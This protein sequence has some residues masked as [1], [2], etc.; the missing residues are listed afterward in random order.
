MFSGGDLE[1]L[2]NSIMREEKI[3]NRYKPII[4]L[5]Q[6]HYSRY[7]LYATREKKERVPLFSMRVPYQILSILE[8]KY[9]EK[10][11]AILLLK[12]FSAKTGITFDKAVENLYQ[13]VV[14]PLLKQEV[15]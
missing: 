5:E 12:E 11:E 7:Y 15:E 10:K 6:R 2:Y 8:Q 4:E 1:A 9:P 14:V 3:P 13:K